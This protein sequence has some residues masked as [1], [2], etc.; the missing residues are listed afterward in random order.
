MFLDGHK[1][2]N[3]VEYRKLFLDKLKSL[4]PYLMEFS[5]DRSMLP[6]EYPDDYII[7]GPDQRPIIII[8]YNEST[9]FAN[10]GYQKA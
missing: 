3:V 1:R 6:Q 9:F 10:N 5:K 2:K 8:I 7:D 4:L